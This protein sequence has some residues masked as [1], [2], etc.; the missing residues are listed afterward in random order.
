[1]SRVGRIAHR[2]I[3]QRYSEAIALLKVPGDV[4]IVT[5]GVPRSIVMQCPNGCGEVI[6]LNVDRRSGPAWRFF[7]RRAMLTI[8]PSIWRDS[9]CR[10]HFIVWNNAILWCDRSNTDHPQWDDPEL[11]IAVERVLPPPSQPHRHFEDVAAELN[12]VPWE[13]LWACRSLEHTGAAESSD[14]GTKFRRSQQRPK[15]DDRVDIRV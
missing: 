14:Q 10:A 1:M 3:V 7:E 8:Y 15:S 6:T 11:V 13:V 4:V 2:G 12:A 5:R 9:G